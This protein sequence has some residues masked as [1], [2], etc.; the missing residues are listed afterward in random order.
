[1]T[2]FV[3]DKNQQLDIR[4]RRLIFRAWH[5]GIR[6]MD[7]VFGPYVDAHISKMSDKAISELEYIMSFEDRDLLTW[8]TGEAIT[9]P[10]V[11]TPLFRDVINYR[12]CIN[13]N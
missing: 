8:I 9:P 4:R 12:V 11:D 6:E 7:L 1:M 10:K 3:V 5:R 13:F 2:D